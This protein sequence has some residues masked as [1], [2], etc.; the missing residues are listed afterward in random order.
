MKEEEEEQ[1]QEAPRD[2]A[3]QPPAVPYVE[4]DIPPLELYIDVG[5]A[6]AE[7]ISGVLIALN[8]LHVAAGG[9]GFRFDIDGHYIVAAMAGAPS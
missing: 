4:Y 3:P 7:T 5:D 8:R 9:R 1:E 2:N 6:T